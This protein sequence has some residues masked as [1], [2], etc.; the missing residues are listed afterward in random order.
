MIF[1][2]TLPNFVVIFAFF[3]FFSNSDFCFSSCG[4]FFCALC[5]TIITWCA[6]F[7][8]LWSPTRLK[9]VFCTG[10]VMMIKSS[11]TKF[12]SGKTR[13]LVYFESQKWWR[14][15]VIA[16]IQASTRDFQGNAWA[17]NLFAISW[18]WI[19]SWNVFVVSV[20]CWRFFQCARPSGGVFSLK[21]PDLSFD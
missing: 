10:D 17:S 6:L 12:L 14:S 3:Y 5:D 11:S 1:F 4:N 18:S 2:T 8:I 21:L 19:S 16:S 13:Y 7:L 9:I 20:Q 15:F